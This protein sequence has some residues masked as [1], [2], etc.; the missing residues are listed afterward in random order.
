M[1][2]HYYRTTPTLQTPRSRS[3]VIDETMILEF[4][5]RN[6]FASAFSSNATSIASAIRL[7]IDHLERS[8]RYRFTFASSPTEE[9]VEFLCGLLHDRMTEERYYANSS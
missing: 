5:P 2:I 4:G 9:D 1:I 3:N 8:T 7:P 6:S